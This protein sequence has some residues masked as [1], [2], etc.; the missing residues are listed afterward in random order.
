M[1]VVHGHRRRLAVAGVNEPWLSASLLH[2]RLAG[3]AA[4]RRRTPAPRCIVHEH[5]RR[6]TIAGV[7]ESWRSSF[8]L[9]HRRLAGEAAGRR[10]VPAPK[11][12]VHEYRRPSRG[13]KNPGVV[14]STSFTDD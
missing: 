4:G 1:C 7:S 5:R 13:S 9:L 3:E 14:P 6:P 10:R 12:L 2:R 11:C 8:H